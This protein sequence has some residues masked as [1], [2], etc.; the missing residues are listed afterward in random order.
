M[1]IYLSIYLSRNIWNLMKL[2]CFSFIFSF[3]SKAIYTIANHN[4]EDW[5]S[6]SFHLCHSH[7]V[8]NEIP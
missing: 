4:I 1:S 6:I 7:H 8:M 2:E 5:G 3:N